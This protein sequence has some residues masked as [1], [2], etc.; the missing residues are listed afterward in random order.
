MIMGETS[1]RNCPRPSLSAH[2]CLPSVV[3]VGLELEAAHARKK[4]RAVT[5]CSGMFKYT[6]KYIPSEIFT[7]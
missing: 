5:F 4:E 2:V 6:I 3:G 1:D 7:I